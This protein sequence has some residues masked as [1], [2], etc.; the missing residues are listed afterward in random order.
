MMVSF[1]PIEKS[2]VPHQ[3][4]SLVDM[5]APNGEKK[6]EKS[7]LTMFERFIRSL[8]APGGSGGK[9]PKAGTEY[10]KIKLL[11][12]FSSRVSLRTFVRKVPLGN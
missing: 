4:S 9:I 11:F 5:D 1:M 3:T 10:L 6:E 12:V 8:S 2:A 7:L